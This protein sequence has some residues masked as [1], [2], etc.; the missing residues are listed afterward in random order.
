MAHSTFQLYST[1]GLR[2]LRAL[3]HQGLLNP[4]SGPLGRLEHVWSN[5]DVAF[6]EP[7]FQ[8]PPPLVL[9][10]MVR[11]VEADE[12]G[13]ELVIPEDKVALGVMAVDEYAQG[14]Q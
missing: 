11:P 12:H 13:S 6:A 2:Q 1:K 10:V 8:V 3:D 4:G 9:R 14:H 5:T 7:G